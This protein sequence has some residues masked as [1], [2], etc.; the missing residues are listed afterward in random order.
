MAMVVQRFA[1]SLANRIGARKKEPSQ[2]P[3]KP[4]VELSHQQQINGKSKQKDQ[5]LKQWEYINES[6]SLGLYDNDHENNEVYYSNGY[7]QNLGHGPEE[8]SNSPKEWSERIHHEDKQKV[9]TEIQKLWD[10][11]KE[12]IDINYRMQHK[13]GS[14]RWIHDQ[15]KIVAWSP[16]GKPT[17][18]IGTHQDISPSKHNE[19]GLKLLANTDSLT[20]LINRTTAFENIR[21]IKNQLRRTGTRSALLF[22][23]LDN[24]KLINDTYSHRT[25]DEVLCAVAKRI[26]ACLRTGDLAARIGGDELLVFLEGVQDEANAQRLAHKLMEAVAKPIHTTVGLINT[27][28]SIGLTL[29]RDEESVD[30][31]VDRAD[32]AMYEA[33]R[34]GRN[35]VNCR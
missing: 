5:M 8:W 30:E 31:L 35:Q 27:S 24:F 13:D 7:V 1:E 11:E 19:E 21:R 6:A 2:M 20:G 3:S 17:R 33:K 34:N 9:L 26:Q 10:K 16:Q 32:A 22:C 4:P 14:Y 15:G 25:G 12:T 28:M 23:D 18:L 29:G